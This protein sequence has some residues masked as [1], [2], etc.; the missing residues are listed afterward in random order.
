[1]PKRTLEDTELVNG[2]QLAAETKSA[3]KSKKEKRQLIDDSNAPTP[4][5]V[6]SEGQDGETRAEKKE[7][8]RLKKLLKAAEKGVAEE[9]TSSS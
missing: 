4:D 3:K 6:V 2:D 8:K 7:K 5:V 9:T 1:M